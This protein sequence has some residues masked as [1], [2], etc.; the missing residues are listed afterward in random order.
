MYKKSNK[1]K[2]KGE[3]TKQSIVD[4]ALKLFSEKNFDTVTVEDIVAER[5]LSVGAFY[6]HFKN[7]NAILE[8]VFLGFDK[9]YNDFYESV[10]LTQEIESKRAADKI[11][12]FVSAVVEI[13]A[14]IGVDFLSACYRYA[15]S[16][17]NR[18]DFV[19]SVFNLERPFYRILRGLITEGQESGDIKKDIPINQIIWDLAVITRGVEMEWCM[20]NGSSDIRSLS[21]S[22]VRNY[23]RGISTC[24]AGA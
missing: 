20:M 2:L 15:I 21:S 11:E 16:G 22:V 6:H 13:C 9:E 1:R 17:K 10:M 19:A 3:N 12:L 18:D 7:K 23:L 24:G 8:H 4:T 14:D 5:G